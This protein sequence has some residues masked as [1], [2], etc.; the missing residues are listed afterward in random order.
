MSK[1]NLSAKQRAFL[2]QTLGLARPTNE[3]A[4][5]LER[6]LAGKATDEDHEY[7]V[8]LIS[9]ESHWEER[10]EALEVLFDLA[11]P[12]ADPPPPPPAPPADPKKDAPK[13]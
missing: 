11:P 4:G 13:K 12:K 3:I 7:I 6:G 2:E 1:Q 10:N 8:D 5:P 9:R